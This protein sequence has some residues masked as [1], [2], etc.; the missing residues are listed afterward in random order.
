M[1][2]FSR[3]VFFFIFELPTILWGQIICRDDFLVSASTLLISTMLELMGLLRCIELLR[4]KYGFWR[5]HS[6]YPSH[7]KPKQLCKSGNSLVNF[8]SIGCFFLTTPKSKPP[9][10][11][12]SSIQ[13]QFSLPPSSPALIPTVN[14]LNILGHSLHPQLRD[15][16]LNSS[17]IL[18]GAPLFLGHPT[19]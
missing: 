13:P 16:I 1:Y 15:I 17:P 6:R 8:L 3:G 10:V 19:P 14:H 11:A 7:S 9:T 4:P 18:F 2:F 12:K 5:Y